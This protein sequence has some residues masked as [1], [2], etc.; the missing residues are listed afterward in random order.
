V[1]VYE[2]S[3]S[4]LASLENSAAASKV[5]FHPCA[6]HCDLSGDARKDVVAAVGMPRNFSSFRDYPNLKLIQSTSYMYPSVT[7]L[8][9]H[10]AVAKY[11]APWHT[12]GVEP[13]AE[14]VISA[15]F[16]WTYGLAIKGAR[17][18][19]CGFG[20]AA[21]SDCAPDSSL[22]DHPTLMSKT[23]GI[24]GYGNIGEAVARRAFGLGMK[25]L[26]SR[27]HGPFSSWLINDSD[28]LLA[29]SD[30]VAVTVPGSVIG[31]IN[32][33]SLALMKPGSVL[34]PVSAPPVDFDALYQALLTRSIGAVLDVW[35]QG[36][37]HYPDSFC[38]PPYGGEAQPYSKPD[39]A[40]LE[41]VLVLP[42]VA[43]RDARFWS[44]SAVW[45]SDN[46]VALL[47]GSTLK[48][49]VRNASTVVE[50]A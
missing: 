1:V 30:F 10:A 7:L 2:T 46:I 17:F 4:Y 11:D 38:G 43:M 20:A 34:I 44:N 3:A 36:C 27:R 32:K 21:P 13:I 5:T 28:R 16:H 26:A 50:A 42:G 31:L 37:W 45:V 35:P 49:V 29:E 12:Y 8:P 39:L 14:F 24:L 15:A 23:M 48:G 47:V 41:N 18:A 19:S 40:K 25:V 22:T 33:T 6:P 9:E